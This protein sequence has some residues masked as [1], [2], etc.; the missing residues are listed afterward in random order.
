MKSH[1]SKTEKQMKKT[2]AKIF[3]TLTVMTLMAACQPETVTVPNLERDVYYTVSE[4][5]GMTA[6]AGGGKTTHLTTE[7]QWDAML[8]RFCDYARDGVQVLFYSSQSVGSRQA[9]ASGPKTPTTIRTGN[10]DDLKAWMKEMEKAG[11]TVVVTFDEGSN[12]WNGVAY[13]NLNHQDTATEPQTYNG[14]LCF[15]NTPAVDGPAPGGTVWA[16]ATN[17]DTLVLTIHGMMLWNESVTPEMTLLNGMDFT[18]EGTEYAN[19]DISGDT[20]MSLE[21]SESENVIVVE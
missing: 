7:E 17:N 19:T 9:K 8:D 12:T 14:T 10:R 4:N 5:P 13:A 21:I 6:L 11:K 20:F 16:L 1:N 18:V 3:A 2:F 15:V